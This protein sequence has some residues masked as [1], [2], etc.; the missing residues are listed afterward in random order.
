MNQYN[1]PAQINTI[2]RGN[3]VINR[4]QS[5]SKWNKL[6]LKT[7]VTLIATLLGLAP[8]AAIG[9]LSY[10]QINNA[11]KEQ[12]A[13]DQKVRATAIA[14][15]LNRFVFERYG[16]VEVLAAQPIFA[17]AKLSAITS[18]ESKQRLLDQ[19]V[20]SYQVYDNIIVFD[21]KGDPIAQSK[22]KPSYNH[23]SRKYFQEVLKTGKTVISEPEISKS[24]GKM[25]VHFAAPI[26]DIT[27]GQIIGLMR[28]RTPIERLQTP[29]ESFA[30]KIQDF[31]ILDRQANKVFISSNG[32][33]GG[34]PA[35]ADIT[36]AITKGELVRHAKAASN[37]AAGDDRGESQAHAELLSAAPFEK[38]EG[39]PQL[40]W[41]AVT[42]IDEE[43]AYATLSGLLLTILSGAGLTALFTV[44]LSTLIA[45]RA[46]QPIVD[47]AKVVE[48][49]GQGDFNTRV[50]VAS[51]D[52]IG[53]LGGNI[54]L[55]AGQ[56]QGLLLAQ[57]EQT[58]RTELYAEISRART[59]EDLESPLSQVLIE[60]R[61]IIKA[62]R[63][64]VYR[65]M[66]DNRGYI[67]GE[68]FGAG[69]SSAISEQVNDPCIPE[70]LL[71][72]YAKGRIIAND[73][74]A[75]SNYHPDHKRLLERLNIKANLIV[76]IVQNGN[77]LG[78]LVAHHCQQTHA[79][80]EW[81]SIYLT[82]FAEQVGISLSGFTISERGQL[83]AARQRDKAVREQ[84]LSTISRAQTTEDMT[85]PLAYILEEGR[86]KLSADRLVIYR[87]FPDLRGHIV[88]E[89]V[90]PGFVSAL[91]N[92]VEDACIPQTYID[93][94]AKG[95]ASANNEVG[96]CSTSS[97]KDRYAKGLAVVNNDLRATNYHPE[98]NQLLNKLQIKSNLIV[99][100]LQGTN[101]IGLIIA[102]HCAEI[103]QWQQSEIDYLQAFSLPIAASLGGYAATE[104]SQYEA[105]QSRQRAETAKKENEGRQKELLRLLM[106]IEGASEGDLTVRSE[107][108]DG[109]IAIVGDF[110]NSIIESLRDIVTKVK[111]AAG[112]VNG[113]VGENESEVR[114]LT[115]AATKQADQ[116]Q[117]TLTKIE[118]VTI[119]IESVATDARLAAN[120]ATSAASS[121]EVG[122]QAMERTV[123]SIVQLRET[124]SETAKKVK[125]LGESSQQISKVTGLIDQ[126]ALQTNLLAINASIEAARAGEEGRGFAVVAEEVGEL[127]AQSAAATK[128]IE[129][130]VETIQRETS[131]VAQAM[132]LSTAQVVEG[133]QSVEQTKTS[134]KQIIALSNQMDTFLQSISTA[135]IDQVETSQAVKLDMAAVA[136]ISEQT[137]DSSKQVSNSLQQ[138]VTIAQALQASVGKFKVNADRN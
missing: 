49:I 30:T 70:E 15:K 117:Q 1:E 86:A 31:H 55:M 38:I 80:Q 104:R 48:K 125:R 126:I 77:L 4:S 29:I 20:A 45:N 51:E 23:L 37:K 78:L 72:A 114:L 111:E 102:H 99:P 83:E 107:I 82:K 138:T 21:I 100:L 53:K 94:Y 133:T 132:E 36:A 41:V 96:E 14:D 2:D 131:A 62:D 88:G 47:A 129:K 79:W 67:A 59:T 76:P 110:F 35:D 92:K 16:D 9:A 46:T 130:I 120:V 137:S 69:G 105:E 60:A 25:V 6:T 50:Q 74:V 65:F 34:K 13:Q 66:A 7:K 121:A 27:T 106:E 17:D 32:D 22:G 89:A 101:V 3:T 12:T 109:E 43:A 116:I 71:A 84:L 135:T 95:D 52:E 134:L 91:D 115:A 61:E 64:V 26:K 42:A 98:H 81:E 40:P 24:L 97:D 112:Q 75:D 5:T 124:I 56:I 123:K 58:K 73:N 128:E 54:N 18:L 108:S 122:G 57:S 44:A 87:F 90:L 103:H 28:T 39:M 85:T 19:Y 33:Y 11:L 10:V 63:L 127:A 68:S 113:S 119:S 93:K 136:L 118:K 8:L